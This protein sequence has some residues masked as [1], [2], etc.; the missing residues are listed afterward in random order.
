MRTKMLCCDE[1]AW[2]FLKCILSTEKSST[3]LGVTLTALLPCS[4]AVGV[5]VESTATLEGVVLL[6][7]DLVGIPNY[8]PR[9]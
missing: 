2:P 1:V 5:V 9:F 3:T 8:E 7:L 4:S 6:D